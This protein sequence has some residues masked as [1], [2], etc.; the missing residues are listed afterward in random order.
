MFIIDRNLEKILTTPLN[1][2]AVV[3]KS[4]IK[5]FFFR[6]TSYLPVDKLNFVSSVYYFII[7]SSLV[8]P[9]FAPNIN[10]VVQ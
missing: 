8:L 9:L 1:L 3:Q 5:Y 2:F 6:T 7:S 4:L 10:I